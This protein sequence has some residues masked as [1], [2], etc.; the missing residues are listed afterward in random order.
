VEIDSRTPVRRLMSGGPIS[1]DERLSLRSLAAVLAD[2]DVGVA[3]VRRADGSAGIVS[4]R[5]VARALAQA[6][7]P[8]VVWA[9]DV[10]AEDLVIAEV[11]EPIAEVA[12]RMVDED[13]RHV[14]VV[15][16]GEVVGVVSLRDVVRVLLDDVRVA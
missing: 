8:D 13:V 16:R 11:D 3:I 12:G 15:D 5:D 4:E 7:D 10:M 2:A 1:V 14:A 6:A 9:A